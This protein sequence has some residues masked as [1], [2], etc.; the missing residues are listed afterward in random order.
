MKTTRTI[1]TTIMISILLLTS[2]VPLTKLSGPKRVTGNLAYID[3]P[4]ATP[5]E[6]AQIVSANNQFAFSLYQQLSKAENNLVFSPYSIHQALTMT[7][8]G[9]RSETEAQMSDVLGLQE[10]EDP[11]RLINAL[12]RKLIDIPE[13]LKEYYQPVEINLANA[14][15]LQN[16]FRLKQEFIDL[17]SS[18][19][20]AGLYLLDF[21]KSEKAVSVI[22]NW[23]STQTNNKIKDLLS[24]SNVNGTTR[25]VLTNAIYFNGAWLDK[26]KP[27]FTGNAPFFSL[28]G[29][30]NDVDMMS[31]TFFAK[32]LV[33]D[34]LSAVVLPYDG[35][36]Y[37][38]VLLMP[39]D[40]S[41]Y[42]QGFNADSFE[43]LLADLQETC[44][45]VNLEMPKFKIETRESLAEQLEALGMPNAFDYRADF[46][47]MTGSRDL[48]ID[49]VI[50]QAMIDVTENGT[51]AAA[52]TAVVMV[53][54]G[55][56]IDSRLDITFNRPF[57]YAI[58]NTETNAIVFMGHFVAP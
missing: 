5:E 52:A 49:D 14:L 32:A 11:H 18:N 6:F 21:S 53:E 22:N 38:M 19:Y 9:A 24:P 46:S 54:G 4:H 37:A 48:N 3:N 8:A 57:I 13:H 31:G 2:C 45:Q 43:K 25:L 10:L 27:E 47:G 34:E 15:W 41:A 36:T 23:V 51:E 55:V 39:K 42:Q 44:P 12:N 58:Y 30:Q 26:F 28:D 17:L 16:D 35:R 40:F 56:S 50:H 33:N 20:D 1:W 29:T 7:Y